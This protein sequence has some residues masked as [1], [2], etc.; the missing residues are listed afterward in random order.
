MTVVDVNSWAA[1]AIRRLH[2]EGG[3]A[4]TPLRRLPLPAGWHVEVYLKDES[5]HPTGT[6]KHRLVRALY[7]HAIASGRIGP[8]TEVVTGTGGPVAVAG[9]YFARLLGLSFTAVLPART[10]AAVRDG[11]ERYGGRWHT[12]EQPPAALQREAAQVA[13]G[14][15]GHA[16]D[17]FADAAQAVLGC[18][19]PTV[20]DEIFDQLRGTGHPVP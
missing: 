20:A 3:G 8:E 12:A 6:V 1:R 13:E 19:A 15:G 17:H 2:A 14:L 10:P 16:L 5:A 7:C 11:V 18:G 4:Q 9:A